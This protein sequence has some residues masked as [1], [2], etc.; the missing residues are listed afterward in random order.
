M[1]HWLGIIRD[2]A[3]FR[4]EISAGGVDHHQWLYN[5]CKDLGNLTTEFS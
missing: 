4:D 1:F 5:P 2:T 3:E